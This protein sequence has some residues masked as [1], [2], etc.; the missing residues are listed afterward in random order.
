MSDLL[1]PLEH[2]HQPERPRRVR[3]GSWICYG[4]EKR[5]RIDLATLPHIYDSLVL[6]LAG[7]GG[8]DGIRR[9]R[10]DATGIALNRKVTAARHHIRN[11]LV[12]WVR[13]ALEDGPWKHYP[14]DD[15]HSMAV[16]LLRRDTW[17]LSHQWTPGLA[18][19][20]HDNVAEGRALMQ[21]N[22]AYQVEI[23][24][25]PEQLLVMDGDLEAFVACSGTVVA[26]MHHASSRELLPS[27]ILCTEHGDDEDEP[28]A[29]TPIQWH[30]LGRKMGRS[31]HESAAQAFLRA[32]ADDAR[33]GVSG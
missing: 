18:K 9:G 24:R 20:W 33:G 27:V 8:S 6:H 2:H 16:W 15:V 5:L 4:H 17:L 31:M 32:I 10:D 1:C 13:I 28:H 11:S 19:E 23:G 14:A 3:D 30:A 21:P 22:T 12:T 7:G 29:W 25:C 26:Q